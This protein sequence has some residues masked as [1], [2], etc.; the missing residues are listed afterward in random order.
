M[1]P[2]LLQ[3]YCP[4]SLSCSTILPPS[5]FQPTISRQKPPKLLAAAHL[6]QC[7]LVSATCPRRHR[8]RCQRRNRLRSSMSRVTRLEAPQLTNHPTAAPAL[9]LKSPAVCRLEV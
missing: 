5:S 8:C 6:K 2:G 1:K 3:R 4:P 7:A 9:R